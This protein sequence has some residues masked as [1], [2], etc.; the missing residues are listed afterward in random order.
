MLD[1]VAAW[2]PCAETF[3]DTSTQST[4]YL[5]ADSMTMQPGRAL[6][7]GHTG[8][9]SRASRAADMPKRAPAWVQGVRLRELESYKY[10]KL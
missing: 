5:F 4:H 9:N 6:P 7:D 8:E 10:S 2:L 3:N 1:L